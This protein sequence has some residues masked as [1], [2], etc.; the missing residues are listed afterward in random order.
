VRNS[1]E[2]CFAPD[3]L[4]K[5]AHV[6][7]ANLMWR[8]SVAEKKGESMSIFVALPSRE[9]MDGLREEVR[10]SLADAAALAAHV[11]K[12]VA[13]TPAVAPP[14]SA[15]HHINRRLPDVP[16][17]SAPAMTLNRPLPMRRDMPGLSHSS[18]MRW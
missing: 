18:S 11:R 14:P 16:R 8:L 9:L 7:S 6:T 4:L 17:G 15:Q 1:L 2:L 13:G 3:Q 5:E 10:A 12:F